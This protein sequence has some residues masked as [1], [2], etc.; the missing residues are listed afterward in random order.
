MQQIFPVGQSAASL[1]LMTV[2]DADGQDAVGA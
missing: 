2:D 1:Q